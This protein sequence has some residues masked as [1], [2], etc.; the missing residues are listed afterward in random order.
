[1]KK[2]ATEWMHT[3]GLSIIGARYGLNKNS[4]DVELQ[5]AAERIAGDVKAEQG[6]VLQDVDGL[7]RAFKRA[8]DR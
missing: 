2:D 8:R 3:I 6:I 1:M 4:S 7:A 5:A